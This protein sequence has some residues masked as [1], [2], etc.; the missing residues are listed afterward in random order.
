MCNA[1]AIQSSLHVS[2]R[3]GEAD[4]LP[5]AQLTNY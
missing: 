3:E 5:L 2:L 4:G 1:E